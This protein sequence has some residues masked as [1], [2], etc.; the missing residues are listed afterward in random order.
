MTV[1]R[2]DRYLTK[3]EIAKFVATSVMVDAYIKNETYWRQK[4]RQF[5]CCVVPLVIAIMMLAAAVL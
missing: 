5:L 1:L 3:E 2:N 4:R